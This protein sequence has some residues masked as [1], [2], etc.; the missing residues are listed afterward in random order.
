MSLTICKAG[1]LL[2]PFEDFR[3][4]AQIC[5]CLRGLRRF[6]QVCAGLHMVYAWFAHGLRMVCAWFTHGL[7]KVGG[8]TRYRYSVFISPCSSF[9]PPPPGI[10]AL[11]LRHCFPSSMSLAG[12]PITHIF[13]SHLTRTIQAANFICNVFVLPSC[14]K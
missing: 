13:R 2:C 8:V 4:F 7:R 11:L 1:V 10:I 14:C 3:L 5:A 9:L 12:H 6:A